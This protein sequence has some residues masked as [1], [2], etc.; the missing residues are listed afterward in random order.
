MGLVQND[1]F[2][3]MVIS[4]VGIGLGYI[5]K[6]LLF[7]LLLS[8]EEI[9]IINLVLTVGLLFAQLANLGTVFTTWKFVPYFKDV[10]KKHHGFFPLMLIF[11]LIGIFIFGLLSVFFRMEIQMLYESKSPEFNT[12]YYWF[13]PIGIGYTLFMFLESYLR[14]FYKNIISVV[15]YELTLRLVITLLLILFALNWIDFSQL[16]MFHSLV[17]LIPS[18]ILFAYLYSRNE[19]NISLKSIKVSKK[20]RK[21]IVQYAGFNYVNTIGSNFV[22]SL[23]VIMIASLI[24]LEET[25]VYATIVF[26]TGALLVPYRSMSRISSPLV[27]DYWKQRET[28]KMKELYTKFSS[29]SLMIGLS[30]F[31]WI[32]MNIDFV[33]S[34]L[35]TEKQLEFAPG[36]WVFFF[37]MMGRLLDMFFGLNGAIFSTSKKFKYDIIFTLTLIIGV[38]GLNL[39]FIPYWGII[40][41]AISTGISLVFYNVARIIF[42]WKLFKIHPFTINQFKIIALGVVTILFGQLAAKYIPNLW[43]RTAIETAIFILCFITPIFVFNLETESKNF[44]LKL[45]KRVRKK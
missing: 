37:L 18:L 39:L 21:I 19:L 28:E 20:F 15:S 9:G 26:L 3:T 14:S 41:A 1:A 38:Y 10:S 45:M 4:Y 2:K 12:Y 36:I 43:L 40:G 42:V 34:F 13:L 31:T 23:D 44:A 32:W 11:V 27:A 16:V 8:S 24:G 5:N 22:Q 33:F 35:P 25:G 30:S 29:V 6:G 7:I 17:Y